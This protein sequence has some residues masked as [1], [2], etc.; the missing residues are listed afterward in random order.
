MK[1]SLL[2]SVMFIAGM[3][4][5]LG[6]T[7]AEWIDHEQV[8]APLTAGTLDLE[9]GEFD[10]D[11]F[12]SAVFTCEVT[13]DMGLPATPSPEAVCEFTLKNSGSIPA[14]IWVLMAHTLQSCVD[15][16]GS[17]TSSA[18]TTR[19]SDRQRLRR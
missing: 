3:V 16:G 1:R 6:F 9:L 12:Q 11:T 15:A 18:T 8:N 2:L 5:V 17:G 13:P 7:A 10:G 4:G 19:T 14:E